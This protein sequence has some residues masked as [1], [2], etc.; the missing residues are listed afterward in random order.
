MRFAS[1]SRRPFGTL[2]TSE[3]AFADA[4]IALA[5]VAPR[6]GD[7]VFG[8]R[9]PHVLASEPA[10]Y[11]VAGAPVSF[12]LAFL[13]PDS[14]FVRIDF[15]PEFGPVVAS[16]V[17]GF[18]ARPVRLLAAADALPQALQRASHWGYATG[19]EPCGEM[20][21]TLIRLRVCSLVRLD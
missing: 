12:A 5:Y 9:V 18:G 17:A 6:Q 10:D 11:L 3:V 14:R 19:G 20:R 16:A 13:Q 21:S 7:N 15:I 4:R 1:C 8:L 2:A